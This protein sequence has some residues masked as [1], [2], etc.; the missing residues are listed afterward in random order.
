[1]KSMSFIG[2]VFVEL[3]SISDKENMK[4]M[5]LYKFGIEQEVIERK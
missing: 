4:N 1:M 3:L 2:F 5:Q